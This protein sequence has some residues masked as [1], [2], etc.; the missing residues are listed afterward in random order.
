MNWANRITMF[1]IVLLPAIIILMLLHNFNDSVDG[2]FGV[3]NQT[4]DFK[5]YHL[6]LSYLIAGILF[7]LASLSDALDG[8]IARKYNLVST[9]G[10]FFDAI[11]DKMLTNSVLIVFTVAN[12]IPVWMCVILICRDFLI[13]VV[14]QILATSKVVMSA[15]NLGK[16][17]AAFEML[18]LSILFFASYKMFDG[19]E[20]YGWVNQVILIPMYIAT[21]LSVISAVNY[22]YLNRV[23]LF[24]MSTKAGTDKKA[25]QSSKTEEPAQKAKNV[26]GKDEQKSE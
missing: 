21:A 12:F 17:R 19:Q 9:F 14:R 16:Y 26:K 3:M 5:G 22:V 13:D 10:K 25:N 2:F 18:G 20:E 15:N 1:R 11:A 4:I 7:I 24:D 8:M 23:V 6:P